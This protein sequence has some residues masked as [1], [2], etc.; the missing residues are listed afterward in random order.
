MWIEVSYINGITITDDHLDGFPSFAKLLKNLNKHQI[1][2]IALSRCDSEIND[3]FRVIPNEIC[4]LINL[5]DLNIGYNEIEELPE[6]IGNLVNLRNLYC[7][8]NNLKTIPKSIGKLVNLQEFNVSHNDLIEL[9]LEI[10]NCK[11]LLNYGICA[12]NFEWRDLDPK[13]QDFLDIII[14]R[15]IPR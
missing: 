12:N 2:S 1:T 7:R 13:I 8:C 14:T 4:E 5:Q 11:S 6:N 9:P 15:N 10:I 3:C